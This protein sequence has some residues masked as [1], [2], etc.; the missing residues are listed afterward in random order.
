MKSKG[1]TLIELLVIVGIIG[2][3][4]AI[5]L[6]N[7]LDARVKSKIATAKG[8]I[9]ACVTALE[10]YRIDQHAI[11]PSRF[12][13]YAMGENYAKKY[14]ELPFELT[15]PVPY[16]SIRA[17]DPFFVYPGASDDGPGQFI[18]YRRPGPGFFNDMPSDEGIWVPSNFPADNGDYIFYND[19]SKENPAAKSPV[20]Y[21]LWSVGPVPRNEMTTYMH[22]PVPN[23]LW[24][25][26]SNGVISSGIITRLNTGHQN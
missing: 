25:N 24:Y 10:T 13:C 19:A 16:L 14:Y 26:V 8:N 23:H 21:G 9:N 4:A 17:L 7:Y 12:Y 1:F 11:P 5:A 20:E 15:S 18:K 22:D 3:L 6:P 2:I